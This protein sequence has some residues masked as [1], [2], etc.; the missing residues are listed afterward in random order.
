MNIQHGTLFTQQAAD[1]TSQPVE[2]KFPTNLTVFVKTEN[3][4]A[5]VNLVLAL[6]TKSP[7]GDWHQIATATYNSAGNQA[8]I[9]Y[10]HA[11][12]ALRAK[13]S[14]YA[15]GKATVSFISAGW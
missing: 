6:E 8:P 3:G 9:T 10:D 13:V 15:D 4:T 14:S 1:G 11:V 5:A 2:L 7:A 12:G